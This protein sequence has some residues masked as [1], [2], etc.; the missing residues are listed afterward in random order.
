[1]KTTLIWLLSGIGFWMK[2]LLPTIGGLFIIWY[3][4]RQ[5]IQDRRIAEYLSSERAFRDYIRPKFNKEGYYN[6]VLYWYDTKDFTCY[7]VYANNAYDAY[8]QVIKDTD[9]KL[10]STPDSIAHGR[11]ANAFYCIVS[12]QRLS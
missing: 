5:R 12:V 4:V 1:M 9:C 2:L 10:S 7:L 8:W 11:K 6:V 3:Y